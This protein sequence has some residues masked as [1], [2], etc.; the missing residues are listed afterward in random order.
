MVRIRTASYGFFGFFGR[1]PHG[2]TLRHA[3]IERAHPRIGHPAARRRAGGGPAARSTTRTAGGT[4]S[5]RRR[6]WPG[7][8]RTRRDED[9]SAAGAAG[10]GRAPDRRADRA[11]RGTVRRHDGSGD[12]APAS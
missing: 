10:R 11:P 1:N 3:T 7:P 4:A 12:D 2:V 8:R 5:A 6:M 9:L